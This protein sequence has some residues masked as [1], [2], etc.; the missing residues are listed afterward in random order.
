MNL[1]AADKI[2]TP[3][4]GPESAPTQQIVV[5]P[6]KVQLTEFTDFL[7]G[8]GNIAETTG[9]P[10]NDGNGSGSGTSM[11]A[12]GSS[13][14]GMSPR[15]LAIANLPIPIVMQKELQTH[16]LAEVKKLRKQAKTIAAMSRP[17]GAYKLNQLYARIRRLNALLSSLL[18]ASVDVIKRL[19]IR[20]FID[21]QNI[22]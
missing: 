20:I 22:Q 17:G 10:A 7:T 15:D 5:Q 18:D 11:Q 1:N 8:I 3:Q 12:T 19:F 2:S 4:P 13:Q 9:G 14:A 21:K 6:S 16:I